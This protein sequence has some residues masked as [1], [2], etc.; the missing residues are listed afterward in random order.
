MGSLFTFSY[1]GLDGKT[2]EANLAT[3][4]VV[5]EGPLPINQEWVLDRVNYSPEKN[6]FVEFRSGPENPPGFI[7]SGAWEVTAEY[8]EKLKSKRENA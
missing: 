1:L 6:I 8:V 5:I 3:L 2:H 7:N 4:E